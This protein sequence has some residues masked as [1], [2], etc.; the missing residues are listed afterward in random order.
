MDVLR[1][2][3]VGAGLYGA[4]VAGAVQLRARAAGGNRGAN[5]A[6]RRWPIATL[7]LALAIGIP[8]ALQFR[9]PVLLGMLERDGARIAAGEWWRLVTALGVQDGGWGGS[10]FN[11][12][13]LLLVGTVAERWWGSRRWLV[14]FWVGG[15][16][17][18]GVA[19]AWQPVGA[20][21]SVANFSLAASVAVGCLA[22]R[23]PRPILAPAILA[24]GADLGLLLLKDIHGAAALVGAILALAMSR[25]DAASGKTDTSAS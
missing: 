5:G 15:I 4:V 12:V 1:S 17:S 14:I 24:L 19:L 10:L 22:N 13:S 25:L 3:L 21:N 11:L 7:L 9:L 20:G 8:T 23:P 2:C 16:V 6:V 18:E